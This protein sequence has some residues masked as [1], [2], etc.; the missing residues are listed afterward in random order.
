MLKVDSITPHKYSG[1]SI[2]KYA[3]SMHNTRPSLVTTQRQSSPIEKKVTK[4]SYHLKATSP[5]EKKKFIFHYSKEEVHFHY[6]E[7]DQVNPNATGNLSDQE[8]L[9]VKDRVRNITHSKNPK[10]K[11][12]QSCP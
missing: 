6:R 5:T 4:S 12:S 2:Y 3:E 10:P 8:D 7:E 1:A 9:I 11:S